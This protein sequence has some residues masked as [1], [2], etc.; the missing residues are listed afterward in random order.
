V[1]SHDEPRERRDLRLPAHK[2]GFARY[3]F[4]VVAT[5][6]GL[7]ITLLV[8]E[9]DVSEQPVYAPLI[10]AV[11]LTAWYGGLGPATLAIVLGWGFS[12]PLLVDGSVVSGNT[13]D[14]TRWWINLAV[15]AALGVI[16]SLL[17]ARSERSADVAVSAS[18][19]VREIEALQQMSIALSSALSSPDVAQVV[20]AHGPGIVSAHGAALGLIEGEDLWIVDPAGLAAHSRVTVDRLP[21]SKATLL[22]EA[23]REGSV[24]M[25]TDRAAIDARYADSAGLLRR[26]VQAVLALPLRAEGKVIGSIGFLFTTSG[27]VTEETQAIAGI[28]AD[29]VAQALERARLYERERESR[30]ALDRILSVAPRFLADDADDVMGAICREARMTFGADYGVLWRIRPD[31]L[32][33]LAIDPPRTDVAEGH[34]LPLDDFPR[35]LEAIR[36]LGTSFVSDVLETTRGEGLAFVRHLGIRSSLRTPVVISGVSEL[37]LAIS[38]QAVVS[39]PDPATVAVVRRFADQAGLALEQL[40]R[41]RAEAEAAQRADSMRRLQQVTAALSLA[42]TPLDVSNTCLEHALESIGAEA[43]FVVLNDPDGTS[44]QLVASTGYEDAELESWRAV[45]LDDDVPFARAMSSGEAVWALSPQEMSGFTS[46]PEAARSAGWVTLPLMTRSGA[47]GALHVSLRTPRVF[48]EAE[49]EWLLSM[50]SQCGQALE[51]SGIYA[52][53]QRSRLRAERLQGM[54]AL[55]SNALTGADVARVVVDE[56]SDAVEATTVVLAAVDEDQITGTLSRSGD[57]QDEAT[58]VSELLDVGLDSESPSGRAVR[59][60]RSILLEHNALADEFPGMRERMAQHGQR[61]LLLVP[62]VAGRRTNGLLVVVWEQERR[63]MPEERALVEALAGQA[64]Q[65]LDRARHFESEQAIA[66]TLQRSVLPVS[67]PRIDGVELAARYLPGSAQLDVGG[68]WFDALRLPDG[69]LGLVVGDV[70][71]KGVEAAA[72]MA[73]LRNAIRAFSIERLKPSSVLARLNRLAEDALDTS[74]ATLAYIVLDPQRSVCRLSSAGHPPPVVAFPDGRVEFLEAARGL[75]LGT[76]VDAK[77]R[78]QTVELPVGSVLVLY[79]DGLVERRGRSIDD[80]LA[81][82][83]AAVASAPKNPD[84]LLEH[85]LERVVGSGERGDDIA[86]LAARVLPVAPRVLDLRVPSHVDSMDLVRDAM[87]AWLGGVPLERGQAEDVVLATWEACAN[88]IEH[89]SDPTHD[90]ITVH[91]QSEDSVVRVM[92]ED[93]GTWGPAA[94]R[95]D[96]GLGLLLIDALASSVEISQ[97]ATGTRI[98]I[99][100][101][102]TEPTERG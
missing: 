81:D 77:Y 95:E 70:V 64:A 87:R 79:T 85:V 76:G 8:L 68:D 45:G 82:L 69:R 96:R 100:K 29:L 19:A 91:A 15:A 99:E 63:L 23:A 67:L 72:S 12:I 43:G 84:Q 39:E 20:T 27:S 37:V 17:R 74:F 92:V 1:T 9:A 31:G 48:T 16:G 60:R 30:R 66:E 46:V 2:S 83:R 6:V 3:L 75:P 26:D 53:E 18:T 41:R 52:E 24:A 34:H 98:T 32:D 93:T 11:V 38:W 78:Q 90:H 80:G 97:A 89:A 102:I 40:E 14:V 49:R 50:V 35:L 22:T 10:G 5:T 4:A 59:S 33:L 58:G 51:R 101:A 73:Q 71:G 94:A 42:A 21:L 88:A 7:V 57:G 36:G 25:A 86:L 44:V 13:D 54:T 47:H 61:T 28:V 55:L 62:L 56:V 65:A